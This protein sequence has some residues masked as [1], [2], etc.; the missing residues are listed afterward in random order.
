[1]HVMYMCTRVLMCVSPHVWGWAE[2]VHMQ[3]C[4]CAHDMW[5]LED[6]DVE[7]LLAL[8]SSYL[9][10]QGLSLNPKLAVSAGL[11]A[12]IFQPLCLPTMFWYYK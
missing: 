3:A 5:K 10:S 12:R 7:C 8:L 11:V 9:R 2:G 1:M 6:A 4:A